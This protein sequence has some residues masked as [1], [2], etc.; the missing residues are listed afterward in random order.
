M[1]FAASATSSRNVKR[2]GSKDPLSMKSMQLLEAPDCEL[3]PVDNPEELGESVLEETSKGTVLQAAFGAVD[4]E[5]GSSALDFPMGSLVSFIF[6]P[7]SSLNFSASFSAC[8]PAHV[9]PCSYEM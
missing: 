6:A 7:K 4:V 5:V 2:P 1:S 9:T 8:S 3:F